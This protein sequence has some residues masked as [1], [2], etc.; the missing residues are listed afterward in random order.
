MEKIITS[1]TGEQN[2]DITSYVDTSYQRVGQ[3]L[4]Y[5]L[6]DSKLRSLGWKPEKIFDD[7]IS[8]IVDYYKTKFIW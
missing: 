5:A 3:D 2:Y 7:E 8:G 6:D 4:R 1:L